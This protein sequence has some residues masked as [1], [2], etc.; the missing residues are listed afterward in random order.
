[1]L[2]IDDK[3]VSLDLVERFFLCDLSCCKGACCVEG[4]AGAPLE[5][6][7]F[8][9]LRQILPAVWA[10]LSPEAQ[11]VINRQ[12][13]GYIDR[14]GD[15]VTSIVDGKDCVFT[16]YD[17]T[18][19]CKCAIEKAY[20]EKRIGFYKPISC[21]LYPVRVDRYKDFQAVNY[22][23]WGIC[24]VAEIVG[25]QEKIPIYRFLREPLI[26]KFGQT[27]YDELDRCAQAY[28]AQKK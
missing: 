23:R 5:K 4:D 15:I 21:H 11:D 20:H 7:E 1:M 17:K 27:W 8:D 18:G 9:L 6:A 19:I 28:M 24:S 10:D 2:Q 25:K 16:Y 12:G 13:V 26:R 22:H 3:L 14:E